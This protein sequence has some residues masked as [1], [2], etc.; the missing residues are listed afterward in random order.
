MIPSVTPSLTAS[1]YIAS[2]SIPNPF[3]E[4]VVAIH[5]IFGAPWTLNY[6][7]KNLEKENRLVVNWGYPSTEKTIEEHGAALVLELQKI[8]EQKPGEPIHF[9]AHS[10]GGLVLRAALNHPE[11]PKEAKIGKAVLMGTPNQSPEWGRLL[12]QF[13]LAN[14]IGGAAG[15]QLMSEEG[16]EGIGEFPPEVEVLVIAGNLSLN[17]F[18]EKENDGEVAVEETRLKTPHRHITL[19]TGH[20]IMLLDKRVCVLVQDFLD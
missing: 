1:S 2:E 5:G 20:K 18:L 15:R 12:G 14:T 3:A 4:S 9:V 16:Y 8:A 13:S 17:P 19:K 10:M 11:C 7:V 6:I